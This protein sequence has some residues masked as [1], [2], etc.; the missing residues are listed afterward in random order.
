MDDALHAAGNDIF[1][2]LGDLDNLAEMNKTKISLN[3]R[4]FQDSFLE[5]SD[6]DLPLNSPAEGSGSGFVLPGG[7]V[8]MGYD[9]CNNSE[10]FDH[11]RNDFGV[12]YLASASIPSTPVLADRSYGFENQKDAF[13]EV[14]YCNTLTSDIIC[15]PFIF[16]NSIPFSFPML[17]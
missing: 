4:S 14:N 3:Q 9:S 5:L 12:T 13:P 10:H 1:E 11:Q 15:F 8:S 2:D 6:L 7:G 16:E 17:S